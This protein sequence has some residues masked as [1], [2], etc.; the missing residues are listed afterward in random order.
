MNDII[1]PSNIRS[2]INGVASSE[3]QAIVKTNKSIK[4]LSIIPKV[5]G[6]NTVLFTLIVE[7]DGIQKI[8]TQ[9]TKDFTLY[10]E[11]IAFKLNNFKP[12][13]GSVYPNP[14]IEAIDLVFDQKLL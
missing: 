10:N 4:F 7:V 1:K 9:T 2:M 8:M 6:L 3:L 12:W 11:V 5:R 14:L 13:T